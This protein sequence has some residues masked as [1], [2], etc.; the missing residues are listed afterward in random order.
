MQVLEQSCAVRLSLVLTHLKT[1]EVERQQ[2]WFYRVPPLAI[3]IKYAVQTAFNIPT[4][5]QTLTYETV[6]LKDEDSLKEM[7][8]RSGDVMYI[9]HL[10]TAD[11]L[12]MKIVVNYLRIL[13]KDLHNHFRFLDENMIPPPQV[14]MVLA[15][16]STKNVVHH[17][18]QVY[19][20]VHV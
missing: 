14:A 9:K 15:D 19:I 5:V 16:Q 11:I 18:T 7:R 17:L 1:G 3:D 6:E 13:L 20:I 12:G 4:F 2:I 8:L 10:G